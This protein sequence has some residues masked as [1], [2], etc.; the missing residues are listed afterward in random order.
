MMII[1]HDVYYINFLYDVITWRVMQC[2]LNSAKLWIQ[3]A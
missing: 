1:M 2:K 3:E